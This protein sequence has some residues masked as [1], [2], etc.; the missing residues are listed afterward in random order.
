MRVKGSEKEIMK[1][2]RRVREE[3]KE[4]IKKTFE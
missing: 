3:I 4:R 1:G 2:V